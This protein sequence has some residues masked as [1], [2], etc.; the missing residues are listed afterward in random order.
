MVIFLSVTLLASVSNWGL[1]ST[2]LAASATPRGGSR[3]G[4]SSKENTATLLQSAKDEFAKGNYDKALDAYKKYLRIFPSDYSAWGRLGATYYH[5]GQPRKAQKTLQRIE[6][7]SPEKSFVYYYQGL[8]FSLLGMESA[9]Q[10]YWDYAGW[11]PDEFG[12]KATIELAVSTYKAKED[13]K[14]KFLAGNY[15]QRFPQ[16]AHRPLASAILKSTESGQPRLEDPKVDERPDPDATI[17]KYNSW[18]LFPTPHFWYVRLGGVNTVTSGFE[19]DENEGLVNRENEDTAFLV[20]VS[21]GLGPVRQKFATAFAG[22]AYRQRWNMDTESIA[23]WTSDP[24]NLELFPLRGDLLERTH[25]LFGDVR[26]QFGDQF[27]AG[28][29]SRLDF[30]RVGSSF[31]PSPDDSALKTVVSLTDTQLFIPWVGWSWNSENRTQFYL[32]FKKEIHNNSSDHSNKTWDFT[33][34]QAVSYGLSHAV[35]LPLWKL[36][37]A[38]EIFQHEFIF[39][40]YWLDYTRKGALVTFDYNIWRNLSSFVL[41]G[42]YED[43]YKLQRI[44]QRDCNTNG[45]TSESASNGVVNYCK[46]SDSGTLMQGGLYWNYSANLRFTGSYQMVENSS[47]MKEYSETINSIKMDVTWAF[48]G[49][50]RVSRMTERFA[51]PAFA[52]DTEQ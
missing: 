38:A 27:Y 32:Y 40:D 50:K 3:G 44:K 36:S 23:A 9:A 5:T 22:Y 37:G 17:Y 29:Y 52:R 49:V 25:Q 16:G 45:L 48:P 26:R 11:F 19:P 39:N 6:Q 8:C 10:K 21:L 2:S 1:T 34:E 51:D 24:F 46:R 41:F 14:A 18:S 33:D 13:G 30:S 42:M 20:D 35:D 15:L 4:N 43:D 12:A 47:G 31:F 28:L 7:L